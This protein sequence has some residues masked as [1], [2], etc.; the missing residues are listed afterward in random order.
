MECNSNT[1]QQLWGLEFQMYLKISW[2]VHKC[3]VSKPSQIQMKIDGRSNSTSKSKLDLFGFLCEAAQ[4]HTPDPIS[5]PIKPH[6]RHQIK[7]ESQILSDLDLSMNTTFRCRF[8]FSSVQATEITLKWLQSIIHNTYTDKGPDTA[9]ARWRAMP[10]VQHLYDHAEIQKWGLYG[11]SAAATWGIILYA[12]VAMQ[13]QSHASD[14]YFRT[15]AFNQLHRSQCFCRHL[16]AKFAEFTK[17]S[18]R[19]IG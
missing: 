2:T 17:F 18:V 6:M 16:N 11:A 9:A 10:A 1:Q 13:S 5:F 12:T 8:A 14:E 3:W 7:I 19:D 4:L 15:Y